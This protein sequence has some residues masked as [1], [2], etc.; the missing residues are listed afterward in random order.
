MIRPGKL[1]SH[2]GPASLLGIAIGAWVFVALSKLF[3]QSPWPFHMDHWD[4]HMTGWIAIRLHAIE[5]SIFPEIAIRYARS[6]SISLQ[7]L[8]LGP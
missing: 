7:V 8:T 6:Y 5:P 3:S 4:Q 1:P 2:Y